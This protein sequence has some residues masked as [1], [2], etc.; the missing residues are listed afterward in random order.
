MFLD[1]NFLIALGAELEDRVVGPARAFLG[2][3]RS[4][5]PNVSVVSLGELAAG[6]QDNQS[7]RDFL[8]RFRIVSLRPEIALAA[9]DI[10]RA[11]IRIGRRLGEND[12]WNAGF[13]LYYGVPLVT[14]DAD[15]KRVRPLGL[16]L[17]S[18]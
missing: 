3:R 12:N 5:K 1:T 10:D 15:F 18:Y 6:M 13:A 9:A 17:L 4:Q 2:R 16:R 8:S 14:N 7:A 11:M